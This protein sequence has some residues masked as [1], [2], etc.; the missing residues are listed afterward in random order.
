MA[1]KNLLFGAPFVLDAA[2]VNVAY[3]VIK[4]L[5]TP[6]MPIEITPS[7]LARLRDLLSDYTPLVNLFHATHVASAKRILESGNIEAKDAVDC[8]RLQRLSMNVVWLTPR[9]YM[10]SYFGPCVF[11]LD[12]VSLL[13][14]KRLYFV[15][16]TDSYEHLTVR[17]LATECNYD[18]VLSAADPRFLRRKADGSWEYNDF[19][20]VQLLIEGSVPIGKSD[21][22]AFIDHSRHCLHQGG[23][24]EDRALTPA[25]AGAI[26]LAHMLAACPEERALLLKTREDETNPFSQDVVDGFRQLYRDLETWTTEIEAEQQNAVFVDIKRVLSHY[27]HDRS[28]AGLKEALNQIGRD[29]LKTELAARLFEWWKGKP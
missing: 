17:F 11:A 7:V 12:G 27:S 20:T 21:S 6:N 25:Q 10:S 3:V 9:S 18:A 26:V 4:T 2:R 23:L 15:E 13:R 24:C 5:A 14:G 1:L 16:E 8:K 28:H 19:Y 29:K 22:L